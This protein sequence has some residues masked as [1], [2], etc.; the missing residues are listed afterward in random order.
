MSELVRER[1]TLCDV[2][3][4]QKQQ[5]Q[6]LSTDNLSLHR[7]ISDAFHVLKHNLQVRS[8]RSR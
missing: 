5:L 4:E 3:A 1:E 8:Y 7:I 6:Q 2:I